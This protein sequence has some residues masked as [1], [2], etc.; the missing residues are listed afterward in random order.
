MGRS[1]LYITLEL[2]CRCESFDDTKDDIDADTS[3]PKN[4]FVFRNLVVQ[5]N[6]KTLD[7]PVTNGS[8]VR[9]PQSNNDIATAITEDMPN[10]LKDPACNDKPQDLVLDET[11]LHKSGVT[12]ICS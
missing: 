9:Y 5:C 2:F 12:L 1:F 7:P 6:D 10:K 11:K 3:K 8:W 4:D